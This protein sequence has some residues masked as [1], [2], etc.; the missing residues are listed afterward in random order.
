MSLRHDRYEPHN[1]DE[2]VRADR[3]LN[4]RDL[5]Q[6]RAA[7]NAVEDQLRRLFPQVIDEAPSRGPRVLTPEL[8]QFVLLSAERARIR[9]TTRIR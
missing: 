2:T 9:R 1:S 7:L 8:N 3:T 5:Q 4:H 6:A